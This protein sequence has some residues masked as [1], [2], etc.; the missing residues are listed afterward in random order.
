MDS[1]IAFPSSTGASVCPAAEV[2]DL[3]RAVIL[4]SRDMFT[5][6]TAEPS[7]EREPVI[8]AAQEKS[9]RLTKK[10]LAALMNRCILIYIKI[11]YSFNNYNFYSRICNYMQKPVS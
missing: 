6:S 11:L 4:G 1:V 2:N 9:S 8:R 3:I 10:R 5:D 7:A